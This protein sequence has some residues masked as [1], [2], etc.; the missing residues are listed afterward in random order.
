VD[1][2][3]TPFVQGRLRKERLRATI[4]SECARS[5]QPLAIEVDSELRIRVLSEGAR[6]VLVS[7]RVNFARLKDPCIIHA[8]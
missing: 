7:P 1:A 8:F 4:E 2:I 6:P 3:A 5:S